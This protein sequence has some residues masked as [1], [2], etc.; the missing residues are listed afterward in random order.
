MAITTK[1]RKIIADGYSRLY[2]LNF[3]RW[4]HYR[5]NL[6]KIERDYEKQ[7]RSGQY[8]RAHGMTVSDAAKYFAVKHIMDALEKP[9]RYTVADTLHVKASAIM[10]QALVAEY[11]DRISEMMDGFDAEAFAALNYVEMIA[12]REAA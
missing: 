6:F 3:V 2:G 12:E 9:D 1:Q 11:K 4:E 10:A 5:E 7:H 8:G